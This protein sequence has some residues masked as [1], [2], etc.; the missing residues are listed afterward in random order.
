KGRRKSAR[1]EGGGSGK[2]RAPRDDHRRSFADVAGKGRRAAWPP[3]RRSALPARAPI[4]EGRLPGWRGARRA[5]RDSLRPTPVAD[6]K[7]A[8]V[9]GRSAHKQ[10]PFARVP[11]R[12]S[13]SAAASSSRMRA[14][15]HSLSRSWRWRREG[16]AIRGDADQARGLRAPP[17]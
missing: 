6:T 7:T 10:F 14:R 12:R 5:R 1:K 2:K 8:L 4:Y 3:R 11:R 9:T 15:L 17:V 13:T 16:A